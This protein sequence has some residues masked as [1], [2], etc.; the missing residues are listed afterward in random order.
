[1]ELWPT[2]WAFASF[3]RPWRVFVFPRRRL[4]LVI[5][6]RI[7]GLRLA[8]QGEQYQQTEQGA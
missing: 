8:L 7:L 3:G 2:N 6:G 5:A 4:S 1:L